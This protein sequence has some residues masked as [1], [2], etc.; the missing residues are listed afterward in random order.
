MS[1]RGTREWAGRPSTSRRTRKEERPAPFLG[2]S[3]TGQGSLSLQSDLG[4][5]SASGPEVRR[6]RRPDHTPGS[7]RRVQAGPGRIATRFPYSPWSGERDIVTSSNTQKGLSPAAA[8]SLFVARGRGSDTRWA[9]PH[10]R[11]GSRGE[12]RGAGT[13]VGPQQSSIPGL[14]GVFACDRR[15]RLVQGGQGEA[16][17]SAL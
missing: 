1:A 5:P 8:G 11:P 12:D 4:P 17:E 6:G 16:G 13:A 7:G 10:S 3:S 2:G 15:L 9:S 14:P